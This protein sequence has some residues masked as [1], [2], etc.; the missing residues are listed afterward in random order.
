[1]ISQLGTMMTPLSLLGGASLASTMAS[2]NPV[3]AY[4]TSCFMGAFLLCT[5]YK[6][7]LEYVLR[8][9]NPQ[10]EKMKFPNRIIMPIIFTCTVM[11]CSL[12][13]VVLSEHD[14]V[15]A[16]LGAIFS[17]LSV[18]AIIILFLRVRE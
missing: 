16:V 12:F 4:T 10:L 3:M 18:I 14:L 11:G 1:M 2:A 13:F 7:L 17:G 9:D 8:M 5:T 6:L 15:P